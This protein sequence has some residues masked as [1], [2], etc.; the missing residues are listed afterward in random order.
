MGFT[1]EQI[2][3]ITSKLSGQLAAATAQA[4]PPYVAEPNATETDY[5]D[6][7]WDRFLAVAQPT[8]TGGLRDPENC[9]EE[10]ARRIRLG[11]IPWEDWEKFETDRGRMGRG[12]PA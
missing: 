10:L 12:A 5:A 7:E 11:G 8:P 6:R 9:S 4:A 3:E 2:S 1:P